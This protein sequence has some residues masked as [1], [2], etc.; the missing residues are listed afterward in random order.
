MLKDILKTKDIRQEAG[1]DGNNLIDRLT[2]DLFSDRRVFTEAVNWGLFNGKRVVDARQ[3]EDDDDTRLTLVLED[4]TSGGD[5][6]VMERY[7]DLLKRA[8]VKRQG[9]TR[10]VLLGI[11]NQT[12][13]DRF[14]PLRCLEY[15]V[16][17][18]QRHL[19]AMAASAGGGD[20]GPPG[21]R[22]PAVVTLVVSWSP[23]RWTAP[24]R[25]R[26]LMDIPFPEMEELTPDYRLNLLEP[27][28]LEDASL[29]GGFETDLG[30][31]LHYVKRLDDKAALTA[32]VRGDPFFR[33]V[34]QKVAWLLRALA[35]GREQGSVAA[36]MQENDSMGNDSTEE[37]IDMKTAWEE[38]WDDGRAT[39]LAE[40]RAEGR[41]ERR[42]DRAES[43]RRLLKSLRQMGMDGE[44]GIVPVLKSTFRLNDTQARRY[45]AMTPR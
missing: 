45:L 42:R 6:H 41:V 8:V 13:P 17:T 40:G 12:R 9:S 26:E 37:Y 44:T 3:L 19:D 16:M 24:R 38:N 22:L 34:P 36:E 2:R 30:K 7:R 4:K 15:D 32:Y 20:G 27:C 35:S 39:G 25:L 31:V 11:E 1:M 23:R 10:F 21:G 28:A 33:R 43:I 5:G 14:M 29:D 18:L